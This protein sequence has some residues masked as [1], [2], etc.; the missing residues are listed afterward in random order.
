MTI[1]SLTML[2]ERVIQNVELK[3]K[4]SLYASFNLNNRLTGLV[5]PRGVGKTTLMLQYIKEHLWEKNN[6]FYFSADHIYFKNNRLYDFVEEL[7]LKEQKEIIFIDEIHKYGE[8]W[9]QELKNLYDGFPTLTIV[10]SGS[11]SLDLIKGS[12]DLSRRAKMYRLPG[13]SFREYLNFTHDTAFAEI[14][15]TQLLQDHQALN[16]EISSYPGLLGIYHEY[17]QQGYYPF[18][19]EE[20]LSYYEKLLRVVEKTIHEDIA[21]FYSLKTSNLQYFS[22]IL[23]YL[24]LI[25]PGAISTYNIGKNLK[26]DDKTVAAYLTMLR[27]TGLVEIIY[28]AEPGNA[29]LRKPEKVFFNNTNLHYALAGHLSGDVSL[30]TIRE[31]AFIQSVVNAD[32]RVSHS[33]AG[34]Y[35]ID[36]YTFEIGGKN[37]TREQVKNIA[38]AFLVKDDTLA[39]TQGSMPLYLLGFL[40]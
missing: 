30:G 12:Y 21:A 1:A 16:R 28:P 8:D 9:S 6:A 3:W 13:L 5:G 18:A 32:L 22:K 10:F 33:K 20:P 15:F 27:E 34:D 29:G 4:R 24:A 11:S 40:Y 31:L 38:K 19:R 35:E 36:G 7:Y 37:K 26:I 2:F 17:L 14:S 39:A 25:P 23:N